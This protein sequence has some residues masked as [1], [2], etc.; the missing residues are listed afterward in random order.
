MGIGKMNIQKKIVLGLVLLWVVLLILFGLVRSGVVIGGNVDVYLFQ[1]QSSGSW[2]LVP[3]KRQLKGLT[4]DVSQ[5]IHYA[6]EQLIAGPQS[7][8]AA[9]GFISCVPV[10]TKIL[11]VKVDN[12]LI[13]LDFDETVETGGGIEE[14]KG[15]LAQI[16]YTATQFNPETGV[17]L[18]I[19]G[20][21]IKSFSG[22][23]ITEVEMPMYRKGFSDFTKGEK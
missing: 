4:R 8:E 20:K 6:I 17:K 12:G 23:G 13:Y 7:D 5:K 15:R 14:I 16:V 11:N 22:E 2:L 1:K 9:E 21:E 18:L 3:V 10:E 19:N